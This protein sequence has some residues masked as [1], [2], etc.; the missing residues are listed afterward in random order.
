M[1]SRKLYKKLISIGNILTHYI[2]KYLYKYFD[3][4]RITE[5]SSIFLAFNKTKKQTKNS[6]P[7]YSE[8]LKFTRYPVYA[9]ISFVTFT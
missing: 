6:R 9:S 8:I 2:S 5:K 3:N 1:F 4:E 7:L